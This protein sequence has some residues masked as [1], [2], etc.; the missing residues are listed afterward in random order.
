M[1][2]RSAANGPSLPK[3]SADF[4]E[5]GRQVFIGGLSLGYEF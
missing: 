3:F 1:R 5:G 2:F 4:I